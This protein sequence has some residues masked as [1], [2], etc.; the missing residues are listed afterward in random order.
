LPI[1]TN[2]FNTVIDKNLRIKIFAVIIFAVGKCTCSYRKASGRE[3]FSFLWEIKKYAEGSFS[4]RKKI[5]RQYFYPQ[6]FSA[7]W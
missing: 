5:Y 4:D 2:N 3:N 7:L 1:I 6:K